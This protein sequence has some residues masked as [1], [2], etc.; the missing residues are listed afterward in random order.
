MSLIKQSEQEEKRIEK[1]KLEFN[2]SILKQKI[3]EESSTQYY[4]QERAFD[5]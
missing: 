1:E 5:N 3:K 4:N 2:K